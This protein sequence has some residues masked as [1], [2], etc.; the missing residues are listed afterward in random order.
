MNKPKPDERLL[1]GIHRLKSQYDFQLLVKFWQAEYE[2][3]KETLV[4]TD[5]KTTPPIQGR[6]AALRDILE[7]LTKEHKP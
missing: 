7:L 4:S 3:L 1:Q 6:A 2:H 5:P